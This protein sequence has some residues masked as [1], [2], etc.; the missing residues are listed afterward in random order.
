MILQPMHRDDCFK[1]FK[2]NYQIYYTYM[3]NIEIAVIFTVCYLGFN[4]FLQR[5]HLGDL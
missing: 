1:I 3:Y 2:I 4:N 5:L